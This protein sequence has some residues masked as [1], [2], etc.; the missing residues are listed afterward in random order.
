MNSTVAVRAF[1]EGVTQQIKDYL[2]EDYQNMQ[3]EVSEQQKNNGVVMTGIVLNMP[4]QKIAPVVYMEPF[5]DQIRKGEPMDQ[6]MNRKGRCEE[7]KMKKKR[8]GVIGIA[9]AILFLLGAAPSVLA[10]GLPS[11]AIPVKVEV[12]G[13]APS[14]PEEFVVQMEAE[15][16]SYPMPEGSVDG[17][18]EMVISGNSFMSFPSMSYTEPGIYTYTIEQIAGL[19]PLCAYDPSVYH[20][21]VSVTNA[22]DGSGLTAMVALRS[23]DA[24]EK[25][26]EAMFT[27]RYGTSP[28]P[29]DSNPPKTGDESNI[30]LYGYLA[31]VSIAGLVVSVVIQKRGKRRSS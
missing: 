25:L 14:V 10:A 21:K 18:F 16:P 7:Y 6:I 12:E 4:G 23:E 20:L 15:D 17:I 8:F 11:V 28:V 22:Q 1:A 31:L 19:N 29:R 24:D 3:C 26:A 13:A 2:P 5:Y 9:L 27:N 30:L